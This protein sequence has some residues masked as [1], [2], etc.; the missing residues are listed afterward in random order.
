MSITLRSQCSTGQMVPSPI[1]KIVN[2]LY[3]GGIQESTGRS[4]TPVECAGGLSKGIKTIR[5]IFC[6][7]WLH[8]LMQIPN[9]AQIEMR[10]RSKWEKDGVSEGVRTLDHWSHNPALYQL[11]YT[12]H[13][14]AG[15]I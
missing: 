7:I 5:K 4:W 6:I 8:Q 14:L 3:R 2:S 9:R 15:I 11:S 12:H 10:N 1:G 13:R